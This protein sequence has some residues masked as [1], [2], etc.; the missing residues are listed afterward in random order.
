MARQIGDVPLVI[1]CTYIPL[2][3]GAAPNFRAV[4]QSLL[5]HAGAGHHRLLRF[6]SGETVELLDQLFGGPGIVPREFAA[7]LFGWTRGNPFFLEEVLKW[8]VASGRL[9]QRSGFWGG[10]NIEGLELPPSIRDALSARLEVLSPG[11]RAAADLAAALGARVS[12]DALRAVSHLGREELLSAVQELLQRRELEEREEGQNVVFDFVHPMIRETLYAELGLARAQTL[13]ATIAE[14]LERLYGNRSTEHAGELAYHLLRAGNGAMVPKAIGY[15]ATA[16]RAALANRADQEAASYLG[17]ALAQSDRAAPADIADEMLIADLASAL[18][19]LGKHEESL[20]LWSRARDAAAMRGDLARVA[21]MERRIGLAHYSHGMHAI[22]LQHYREGLAVAQQTGLEGLVV[23]L[24]LA[25][26]ASMMEM[27]RQ[28][29]ARAELRQALIE[30]E[31]SGDHGLEA[32]THRSLLLVAMVTCDTRAAREHAARA[33]SL[34]E[35]SRQPAVSWSAYWALAAVS[36]LAGDVA[37]TERNLREADRIADEM[38][39]PISR[40]WNSEVAI[41]F[42]AALGRWQAAIT[43]GEHSIALARALGQRTLLPRLLVWTAIT[44]V[45]RGD[46]ERAKSLLDEAWD[47]SGAGLLDETPRDVTG[48]LRAQMGMVI[49]F[50]ALE[51][52]DE[53]VRIGNEGLELAERTGQTIWS[54][55]RLLPATIEAYLRMGAP[56]PVPALSRRLREESERVGHR[57]G[58][59]WSEAA[60]ALVDALRE[61][62][63]AAMERVEAAADQLEAFPSV[64]DAAKLRLVIG[65]MRVSGGDTE[66]ASRML[67]S[68]YQTFEALGAERPLLLAREALERI[69]VRPPKTHARS[70]ADEPL[71]HRQY[72]IACLVSQRLSNKQIAA[73]L[74]ITTATARTHVENIFRKLGLHD[75]AELT[76][77][78]RSGQLR[79][80]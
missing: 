27:G 68:A 32:R 6:T 1:V 39:S 46:L 16:G 17:S 42:D 45:G 73:R 77:V 25:A 52:F 24:R 7:L 76:D 44:Y 28:P 31:R 64:F 15:L 11:A 75:R 71:S 48:M 14:A 36:G 13:H 22:A 70:G 55:Y 43:R 23:Q 50:T 74:G 56:G 53:A 65:G 47:V 38:R 26:A 10:W 19:R 37:E 78:V 67:R 40:L 12:L 30:A 29:E 9:S 49:Y 62:S 41:E 61:L 60:D 63:P 3:R 72:E 20:A 54:I 58:V 66:G 2:D 5:A 69:G 35:Q 21:A 34:A 18:Q 4:E 80:P 8:L 57:L 59:A 79:A 51:R 33:L